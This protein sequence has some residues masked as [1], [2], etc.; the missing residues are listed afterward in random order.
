MGEVIFL[1]I[2]QVIQRTLQ[3]HTQKKLI[4]LPSIAASTKK[5]SPSKAASTKK[6]IHLLMLQSQKI[7]HFLMLQV[8]EKLFTFLK[9]M[10]DTEKTS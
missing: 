6:L 9:K 2:I 4:K 7:I 3:A 10:N 1:I 8:R 5:L